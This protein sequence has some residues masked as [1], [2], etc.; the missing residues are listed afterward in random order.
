LS[1]LFTFCQ[2]SAAGKIKDLCLVLAG[3]K[4]WNNGQRNC[5]YKQVKEHIL[6]T[7]YVA[8]QDM[9]ALYSGALVFVSTLMRVWPPPQKQCSVVP[10]DYL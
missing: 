1:I 8:D 5:Y 10:S 9:A 4:G 6:L 3:P 7:G 2:L